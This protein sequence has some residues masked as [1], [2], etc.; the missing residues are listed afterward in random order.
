METLVRLK[1]KPLGVWTTPW[2]ADS[3][4]GAMACTWAR[5]R[6]QDALQRDFLEP[7][8]AHEPLFVISDAFP[9]DSLPAPAGL[10]LWWD[11]PAEKRK[12][13]KK[14]RWMTATDFCRVQEGKKPNLKDSGIAIRDRVR[15]RNTISRVSNTT[16]AGGELFEVPFSNL[17]KPDCDLTIFARATDG[18]LQIL[19]EVLGMLGRTGYGADASVGHGSFELE[20]EP[21]PCSELDNVPRADGFISLSTFQPAATDPVEGFWRLFVKYGKLAPEFHSAAVFK[22]P[23][24]MLSAGACFRTKHPP[25]PFYGAPIGPERLLSKNARESLA[26]R[27]VHPVQAAFGLAVPMIWREVN[28]Q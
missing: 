25:K 18:G 1:L 12:N 11:W 6:G 7:W 22:R 13:V 24:V 19:L 15:L 16:G 27:G 21:T 4:L 14:H 17:S 9:G 3:L 20:G 23:Q 2:Q 8:L 10:S 28:D 5:S 26:E